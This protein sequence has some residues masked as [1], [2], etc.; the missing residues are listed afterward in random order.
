MNKDLQYI[1]LMQD[2]FSRLWQEKT[3]DAKA[4]DQNVTL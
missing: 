1:F 4:A 3:E 2:K